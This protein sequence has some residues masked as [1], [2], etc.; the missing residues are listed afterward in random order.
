MSDLKPSLGKKE[1]LKQA[2]DAEQVNSDDNCETRSV[3]DF[4]NTEINEGK[5]IVD[6]DSCITIFKHLVI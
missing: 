3:H 2:L 6:Y 5:L 1:R 4:S